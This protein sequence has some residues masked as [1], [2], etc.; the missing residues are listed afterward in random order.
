M[1]KELKTCPFCDG[2]AKMSKA[3]RAG[4]EKDKDD[5]DAYSYFIICVSCAA[6]G[7]WG[8]SEGSAIRF[9]NMRVIEK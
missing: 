8:K 9:W 1:S 2:A 5:P 7:G 6:T 3:L 4:Y